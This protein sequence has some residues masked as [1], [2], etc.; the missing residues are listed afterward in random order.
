MSKEA[1]KYGMTNLQLQMVKGLVYDETFSGNQSFAGLALNTLFQK[2]DKLEALDE[3]D[4][5]ALLFILDRIASSK[6]AKT[7]ICGKPKGRPK[8]GLE[9]LQIAMTVYEKVRIGKLSVKAAQLGT[10][11]TKR[12]PFRRVK[13]YWLEWKND[14]DEAVIRSDEASQSTKLKDQKISI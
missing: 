10:A 8:K 14:I 3:L 6:Q 5:T 13:R 9:S 12:I 11:E 1:D 2:L 7:V 4:I